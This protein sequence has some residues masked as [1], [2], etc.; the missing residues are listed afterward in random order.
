MRFSSAGWLMIW[1]YAARTAF[2]SLASMVPLLSASNAENTSR[3]TFSSHM[4]P[5]EQIDDRLLSSWIVYQAVCQRR[6]IHS[7]HVRDVIR[8]PA[9]ALKLYRLSLKNGHSLFRAL[10]MNSC[11]EV[12]LTF[13]FFLAVGTRNQLSLIENRGPI[14]RVTVLRR[15]CAL[16]IELWSCVHDP[17]TKSSSPKVSRF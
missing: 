10:F 14:D 9:S 15:P 4:L 12:K 3:N 7:G 17:H 2:N 11:T 8:M 16:D 5:I 13:V 6:S 1:K